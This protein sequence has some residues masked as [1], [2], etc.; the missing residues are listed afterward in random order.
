IAASRSVRTRREMSKREGA[1]S[2]TSTPT[3]A[4]SSRAA[5]ATATCFLWLTDP[6]YPEGTMGA[7]RAVE[8]SGARGAG[9]E[10]SASA[11]AGRPAAGGVGGEGEGGKLC[12]VFALLGGEGRER[13]GRGEAVWEVHGG[14]DAVRGG[15]ER[16]GR[17]WGAGVWG[18]LRGGG[19]NRDGLPEIQEA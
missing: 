5:S 12:G 16:V 9:S 18:R 14:E 1:I 17:P 4:P 7:P 19:G 15:E 11:S 2:S 8:R 10:V 13:L 6:T 3:V